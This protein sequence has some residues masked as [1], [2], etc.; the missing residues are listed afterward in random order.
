M[1]KPLHEVVRET[2]NAEETFE[3]LAAWKLEEMEAHPNPA[4]DE[5][6][7]IGL[8]LYAHTIQGMGS[9]TDELI[10]TWPEEESAK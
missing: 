9:N 7:F 6:D 4:T 1:T 2:Q 8:K 3:S 10:R 5:S